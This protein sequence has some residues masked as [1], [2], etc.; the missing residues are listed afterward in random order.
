[1]SSSGGCT[2]GSP[3]TGDLTTYEVGLG[4]CGF[5]NSGTEAVVAISHLLMGSQSN[6]NPMCG[7]KISITYNGRTE[8]ATV[9]D[10]CGGCAYGSVDLSDSLYQK[11]NFDGRAHGATWSFL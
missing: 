1:M 5:T 11:F 8:T 9:V 6:G 4:S 7:K 10:K 2:S 3:C